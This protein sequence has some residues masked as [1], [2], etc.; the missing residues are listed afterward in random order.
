[1]AKLSHFTLRMTEDI[2]E[3]IQEKAKQS[4]RSMNAEIIQ[5]IIEHCDPNGAVAR[6]EKFEER[7]SALEN[8][9]KL[10][11]QA[12]YEFVLELSSAMGVVPEQIEAL[13]SLHPTGLDDQNRK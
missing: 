8:R 12:M 5:A 9:E 7:I 1:M 3:M 2:Q 4:G 10:Q 11:K 6:I 13:I